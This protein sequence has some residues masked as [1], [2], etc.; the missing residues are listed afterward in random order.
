[1]NCP[2]C[3]KEVPK[4]EGYVICPH[5]EGALPKAADFFR[6]LASLLGR[7]VLAIFLFAFVLVGVGLAIL[8]ILYA[9]CVLSGGGKL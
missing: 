8:A 3:H 9:G 2:H 7:I 6:S 4:K 1:M 5:C